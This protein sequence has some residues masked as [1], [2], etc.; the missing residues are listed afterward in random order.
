[1][2][3]IWE[4]EPNKKCWGQI[5]GSFE[6][7]FLILRHPELKHL[8]GYIGIPYLESSKKEYEKLESFDFDVHGGIRIVEISK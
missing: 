5:I 8:C 6:F 1:M 3:N 2:E 7:K 4:N